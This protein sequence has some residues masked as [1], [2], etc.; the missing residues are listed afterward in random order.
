MSIRTARH[1]R[2]RRFILVGK[3]ERRDTVGTSATQVRYLCEALAYSQE[4]GRVYPLG[5]HVASTPRTALR[6]LHARTQH[7]ADQLDPPASQALQR[8]LAYLP[9]HEWVLTLLRHDRP[10]THTFDSDGV[11]YYLRVQRCGHP[12]LLNVSCGSLCGQPPSAEKPSA[13]GC[14]NSKPRIVGRGSTELS[15]V[16]V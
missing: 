2:R 10:Y 9:E 13:I 7:I 15:C 4:H 1:R 11:H 8:W 14:I 3:R 16:W 6:W 5:S 12:N